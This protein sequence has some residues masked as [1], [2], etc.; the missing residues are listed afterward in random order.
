[1][2]REQPGHEYLYFDYGHARN[3]FRQAVRRGRWKGIRNGVGAPI[4]LYDLTNDPS[5]QHDVAT[6]NPDEVK[7]LE[8]C[9]AEAY[10]PSDDYPVKGLSGR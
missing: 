6:A 8:R 5:E 7:R 9:L 4:E 2:G 10:T 3:Q 1:M